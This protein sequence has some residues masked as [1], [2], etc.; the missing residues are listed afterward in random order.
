[1]LSSSRQHCMNSSLVT[2]PSSFKSILENIAI[3][4]LLAGS[5]NWLVTSFES[6]K[7]KL[8]ENSGLKWPLFGFNVQSLLYA[9]I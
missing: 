6:V 7:D 8:E 4:L 9:N 1:M 2:L 5:C 3:A